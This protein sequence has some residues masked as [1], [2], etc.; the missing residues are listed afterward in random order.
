MDPDTFYGLEF[1]TCVPVDSTT[2]KNARSSGDKLVTKLLRENC[3][4]IYLNENCFK[5][6]NNV[7]VCVCGAQFFLKSKFQVK[8]E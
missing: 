6:T 5:A 2:S 3:G 4:F 8:L 7:C 1:S